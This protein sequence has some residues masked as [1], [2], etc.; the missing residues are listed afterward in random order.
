MATR[1]LKVEPESPSPDAIREAAACL[2]DGGL[3][4]IPTE[5]VYGLAANVIDP[6]ALARLRAV[7]GREAVKPFTVHVG[8]R[9]AVERFVPE[10]TGLAR[11]LVQ[12]AWP[13]PLTVVFSVSD[14][15][16]A[17]VIRE[18]AESHIPSIYHERTVGIRCPD[19]RVASAVLTEAG[20]PVVAASANPAGAP[21]PVTAEEAMGTLAD[22]VDLVLDA[23]RTRYAKPSTIIRVN[24]DG[25]ELL[26]EGII[27][28]RTLQKLCRVSFLTV[29]TGNTCRS[30]MAEALLRRLL[31]DRLGCKEAELEARGYHVES[32]GV[33]AMEGMPASEPAVAVMKSL[34]MDL[35]AHRSNALTL[36]A[37]A[38][39]DYIFAMT[40][41]HLRA[42]MRISPGAADRCRLLDDEGIEDPIGSDESEYARCADAI[43][44][45]LRRKLQEISL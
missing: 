11:R 8:S 40:P 5:T 23:G 39:A 16:R 31:A 29:C 27:A 15:R 4:V 6:K 13:G 7:K 3:V 20:V 25:Y 26:R 41:G 10:L 19:D 24:G 9:S 21:A 32:A 28:E 44:K 43:E 18:S 36:E 22:Q 35:S 30:P 37:I 2:A 38:R 33:S 12:K 17:A 42:V 45:A 34:G 1:I 14:P